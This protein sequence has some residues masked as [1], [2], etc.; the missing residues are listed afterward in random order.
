MAGPRNGNGADTRRGPRWRRLA[1]AAAGLLASVSALSVPLTGEAATNWWVN[2]CTPGLGKGI[3]LPPESPSCLNVGGPTPDSSF[4]PSLV[5][6]PLCGDLAQMPPGSTTSI[7]MEIAV[8]YGW[9]VYPP[10]ALTIAPQPNQAGVTGA[11]IPIAT[12]CT[13]ACAPTGA[14]TSNGGQFTVQFTSDSAVA[15][16]DYQYLLTANAPG[17]YPATITLTLRIARPGSGP[18]GNSCGG[19]TVSNHT[20]YGNMTAPTAHNVFWG[21]AWQGDALGVRTA[22]DGTIADEVATGWQS[23]LSQ[24]GVGSATWGGSY[25]DT[26]NDAALGG[27]VTPQAIAN[28]LERIRG[29]TGWGNNTNTMW[30][31]FLPPNVILQNT[32][33]DPTASGPQACAWHAYYPYQSG[34]LGNAD[35]FSFGAVPYLNSTYPNCRLSSGPVASITEVGTHELSEAET[36]INGNGWYWNND[37]THGEIGDLCQLNRPQQS[38][39]YSAGGNYRGAAQMV[40]SNSKHDCGSTSTG[41]YWEVASDGGIFT[42]GNAGFFGS[43][44]GK[45]LN[46]PMVGMASTPGGDGYWEVASD[47][48]IFPYGNAAGLGSLGNIRL[49]LPVVGMAATPDGKGYWLVAK[50]GGIFTFGDALFFGSTGG[51]PP[52]Y[53]VVS[54]APTADGQG[55][56]IIDSIGEVFAFGDAQPV[57]N[58]G[59]ATVVGIAAA[60][61]GWG[62]CIATDQLWV[63]ANGTCQFQGDMGGTRLSAAAVGFTS[64]LGAHGYY[65]VAKDGGIFAF[66]DASFYGS[67]GGH[68]L[69]APMVGMAVRP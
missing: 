26:G 2:G 25:T 67:M 43:M 69:N 34:P 48:G 64:S 38:T 40:Y 33:A 36:D 8:L 3:N 7:C 63:N 22:A 1:L 32:T 61:D 9:T 45:P 5:F 50:D 55:Y 20:S 6:E 30:M 11:D 52:N 29:L 13:V 12:V 4:V 46:Q 47:G 14:I 54:M 17:L 51:H 35:Y 21:S 27:T 41:G 18:N 39:T 42:F 44:G 57:H 60:A 31:V 56:W 23:I 62:Y 16:G 24:Y 37:P 19:C 66:G 49:N 59:Q 28:E 68:A 15:L 58:Y 53:P 65:G 10:A